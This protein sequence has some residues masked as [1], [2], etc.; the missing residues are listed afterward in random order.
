MA[1][2]AGSAGALVVGV[3]FRSGYLCLLHV[4]WSSA[5][6]LSPCRP[7]ARGDRRPSGFQRHRAGVVVL[8]SKGLGSRWGLRVVV[9]CW[10][11]WG[12]LALGGRRRLGSPR[13]SGFVDD[14][15]GVG[16]E[17]RVWSDLAGDVRALAV[18]FLFRFL[19]F[20]VF[21]SPIAGRTRFLV[22]V[23]IGLWQWP[24]F[25]GSVF[26][27]VGSC[28]PWSSFQASSLRCTM[29]RTDGELRSVCRR[30][31]GTRV[32]PKDV[33]PWHRP[34]PLRAPGVIVV[35][36]VKVSGNG[37]LPRFVWSALPRAVHC[38]GG[39]LVLSCYCLVL[40]CC[41]LFISEVPFVAVPVVAFCIKARNTH[42]NGIS[43]Y[44][45]IRVAPFVTS[46]VRSGCN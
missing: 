6:C 21:V 34:L 42:V 19:F 32:F 2:G 8:D 18:C 20:Q 26:L 41:C 36:L 23:S 31:G 35:W 30:K 14:D 44:C 39:C 27:V 15:H 22:E 38:N 45:R 25:S 46:Q 28:L 29:A 16:R 7:V 5:L 24:K 33:L 4:S 1:G 3:G 13:R 10:T 11:L 37:P 17:G 12:S 43:A 40:I 9:G